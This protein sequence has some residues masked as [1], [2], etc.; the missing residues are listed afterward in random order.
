VRVGVREAAISFRSERYLRLEG[1]GAGAELWDRVTG[2]YRAADGRWVRLHC[3]YP[4]HRLTAMRA[5]GAA[6]DRAS[7]A[8]AVAA[9][10][11]ADVEERVVAAGG[12]AAAMRSPDE[13]ARHPQGQAVAG[14]PLVSIRRQ[15]GVPA[16]PLRVAARPLAGVRVLDLTQVIAGPVCGRTLAALG[17]DV[18]R[19]GADHLPDAERLVVDTGFGK[20]SCHLDLRTGEGRGALAA[21]VRECDVFVQGHRPGAIAGLGFGPEAIAELRPGAIAVSLSA[22]GGGGPWGSRRG[23]DSLVQMASGIAWEGAAAAGVDEPRPLPAQALDHATGWLAA[24]GTIA[25][26]RRRAEEGGSWTVEVSLA[27]TARWLDGLGRIDG[28]GAPDPAAEDVAD[29]LAVTDSPFGRVTHV[30]PP[31]S[32]GE[33]EPRWESPAPP[34]RAGPRRLVVTRPRRHPGLGCRT[35]MR[36]AGGPPA[37]GRTTR[38]PAVRQSSSPESGCWRRRGG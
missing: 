12:C 20:R 5:V 1:A 32:I 31:G 7:A 27:R 36:C 13:W 3:N 2:D 8:A 22:Y 4:H 6:A 16:P 29:L 24:L 18:L 19:V 37:R 25:A 38:P 23:F 9:L 11:A 30:R 15:P 26:L 33:T 34:A 35:L 17:A 28:L 10:P 21:L 14:L